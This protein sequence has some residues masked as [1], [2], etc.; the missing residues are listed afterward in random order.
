MQRDAA[1]VQSVAAQLFIAST[2][3]VLVVFVAVT[4][5]IMGKIDGERALSRRFYDEWLECKA[6]GI[7]YLATVK[8]WDRAA[9]LAEIAACDELFSKVAVGPHIL[10]TKLF[11]KDRMSDLSPLW[12]ELR[13][14]LGKL[15]EGRP[16]RDEVLPR[17]EAFMRLS[18][19][20][21]TAFKARIAVMDE[22][23]RSQSSALV[24]L[25][26]SAIAG[27]FALAALSAWTSRAAIKARMEGKRLAEL[28]GAT[29][30]AQEAERRRISLELHDSVAQDISAALMTARRLPTTDDATRGGLVASL[31]STIDALRRISW[32]MRPPELER[33][34]FQ[35]AAMRLLDAF[36]EGSGLRT[37]A[38]MECDVSGLSEDTAL[39][40]YR[41]LQESLA[42]VK[43]HAD[44]KEIRIAISRPGSA[45][46]LVIEDDGRGFDPSSLARDLGSPAHLGISGMR[47]RARLIGGVLVV[48]SAPGRGTKIKVEAPYA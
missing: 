19:I 7:F 13:D 8:H 48:A 6:D 25:Q 23:E 45:V 34:G 24:T 20:F 44:A 40:L 31:K 3:L 1:P 36:S 43:K 38:A 41:I 33:F 26:L 2:I 35:G 47:E 37:E 18:T 21:E 11:E 46:R 29:F 22:V 4:W 28:V 10:S 15:A 9:I 32:E 27:V 42:N 5:D 14:S 39:H 12:S 16:A 30:S 17:S